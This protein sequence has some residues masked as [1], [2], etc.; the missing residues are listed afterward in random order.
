MTPFLLSS[1]QFGP[2]C[3]ERVDLGRHPGV[4]VGGREGGRGAPKILLTEI[5]VYSL[6]EPLE[7][8]SE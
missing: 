8:Q 6:E 4:A 3:G 7:K 5:G 2:V 1:L